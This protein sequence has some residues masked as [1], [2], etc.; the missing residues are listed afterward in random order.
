MRLPLLGCCLA[1]LAG[2]VHGETIALASG[3]DFP[4]YAD[5]QLPEGG[6]TTDLVRRSFAAMKADISVAWLP[7]ARGLED[8]KYGKFV[9]TFPYSKNAAREKE[10]I[11]STAIYRSQI[12]AYIK[13]GNTKFDFT[14]LASLHGATICSPVGY[15]VDPKLTAMMKS[16]LIKTTAPNDLTTC[17]KM[18]AASHADFFSVNEVSGAAAIKRSGVTAGAVV[19]ADGPP[20]GN[21]EYYL[22][23]SRT[24]PGS[25]ELIDRFD[26]G[27]ALIQKNGVYNKVLTLHLK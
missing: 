2:G 17:V 27:L 21:T 19:Q 20:I 18:V 3:N 8:T 6:M 26:K 25:Q 24:V 7:W 1:L 23:A 10:F 22:I 16:G 11:Y 13:A 12:R 15:I 9:A 5:P 4:P 14:N